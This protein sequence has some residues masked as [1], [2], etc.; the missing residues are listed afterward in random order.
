VENAFRLYGEG[1]AAAPVAV[2]LHVAAGGFQL[3]GGRAGP[4]TIV[5]RGEGDRKFS[6]E[7]KPLRIADVRHA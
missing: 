6:G 3:K 1:K 7:R 5:L 2:S 4:G